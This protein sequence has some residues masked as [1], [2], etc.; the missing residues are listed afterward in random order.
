MVPAYLRACCR[1]LPLVTC[2]PDV[3]HPLFDRIAL[4]WHYFCSYLITTREDAMV[5]SV[6]ELEAADRDDTHRGYDSTL[7]LKAPDGTESS[8]G[9]KKKK[10]SS[11]AGGGENGLKELHQH[12]LINQGCLAVAVLKK[13]KLELKQ[14]SEW[15]GKPIPRISIERSATMDLGVVRMS[16]ILFD[17][18]YIGDAANELA[19]CMRMIETYN[20]YGSAGLPTLLQSVADPKSRQLVSYRSPPAHELS[21]EVERPVPINQRQMDTLAGLRYDVEGIQGEAGTLA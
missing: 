20:N 3:Q 6:L 4:L 2:L 13:G 16:D 8:T 5:T 12:L 21:L 17:L 1:D 19:S 9:K 15:S 14:G 7:T 10:K 11:A 18:G